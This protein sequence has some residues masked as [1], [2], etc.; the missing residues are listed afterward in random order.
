MN[1]LQPAGGKYN[2]PEAVRR[3]WGICAL[4]GP[5]NFTYVAELDDGFWH[6]FVPV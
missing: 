6:G 1:T 5:H 4:L 2:C 3:S